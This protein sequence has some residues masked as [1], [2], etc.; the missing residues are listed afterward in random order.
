VDLV[1]PAECRPVP[2]ATA[3]RLWPEAVMVDPGTKLLMQAVGPARATQ[4][5]ARAVRRR[6]L[7]PTPTSSRRTANMVTKA[8]KGDK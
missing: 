7:R 5:A 2:S 6:L 8:V 4:L 3:A 1:E